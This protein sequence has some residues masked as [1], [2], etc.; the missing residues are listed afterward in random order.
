MMAMLQFVTLFVATAFAA[1]A[2]AAFDWLLLRTTFA[3]MR[4]ATARRR[5]PVRAELANAARS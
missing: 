1:V 5:I 2:A 3:L 4:P